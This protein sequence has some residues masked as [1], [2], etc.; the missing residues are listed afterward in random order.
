MNPKLI[1]IIAAFS[2]LFLL[3]Q[4]LPYYRTAG[5]R[6]DF[7][8]ESGNIMLALLNAA[9][10]AV[11]AYVVTMPVLEWTGEFY[12]GLR[13]ASLPV[14][15]PVLALISFLLLDCW[16]Y[17]WHRINHSNA[18]FWRFHRVHHSDTLLSAS[19]HFRFHTGE[20][21]LSMIIR[22]PLLAA[23]GLPLPYLLAYDLVL[24]VCSL[25]QH[26]N[27]RMAEPVDRALRALLVTPMMHRVH[28]STEWRET[29]SNYAT[30][31]SFWDRIFGSYRHRRY[32]DPPRIG[33]NILRS[34]R[35][36]RISNLLRM[37]FA[38]KDVQ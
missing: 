10:S 37:P 9:V 12:R 8:R 16:T 33:M 36:N 14:P 13:A 19:T 38:G 4:L 35:W 32:A 29:N 7:I 5:G 28:H 30:V 17:W 31:F 15:V 27:F 6:E 11:F 34:E 24:N 22:L 26:G 2:V 23:L 21:M 25:F 3:E 1:A 18:F 20:I